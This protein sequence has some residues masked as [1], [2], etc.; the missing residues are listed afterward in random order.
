MSK[1]D[2]VAELLEVKTRQGRRTWSL[3]GSSAIDDL[4]RLWG[5]LGEGASGL[6]DYFPIRLVTIIEVF[7]RRWLERLVDHG[8][9]YLGNAA[10]LERTGTK[11]DFAASVAIQGRRVSL[12]QLVA[13]G[14]SLNSLEQVA[15]YFSQVLGSDFFAAIHH[16]H[17]RFEVERLGA[18]KTPIIRD[19]Q[20]MRRD[21][22]RLFAARHILVHEMP[23]SRPY[24]VADVDTFLSAAAE[25]VRATEQ[26]F[27]NCLTP[28]YPLTT[29]DMVG[30]A[31]RAYIEAKSQL[32][33]VLGK[34]APLVH[35]PRDR[36]LLGQSQEAWIKYADVQAELRAC[37]L[38]GGSY[39]PLIRTR[40]AARLTM[41]RI[42]DLRWWLDRDE[43][44]I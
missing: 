13:H 37:H 36:N 38:E 31:G 5:A 26:T 27:Q 17:D 43:G 11:L 35:D 8:Q 28:D 32:Q 29:L 4:A 2:P 22:G 20:L 24:S 16:T 21:L 14:V 23:D 19:L 34:I 12:G 39:Q 7:S 42:E 44:D 6:M 25:F 40:E 3:P 1:R 15:G 10:T 41:G 30:E 33:D 9:P 18:P